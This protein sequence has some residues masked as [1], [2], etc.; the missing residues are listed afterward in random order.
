MSRRID[1]PECG[2][3]L[4]RLV[5]GGPEVPARIYRQT[6]TCE[7]G[8]A[9][10]AMDRPGFL[11]AEISGEPVE[12]ESVWH[13]RGREIDSYE[14]AVALESQIHDRIFRPQ[15]PSANP[16]KRIDLLTTAL[17]F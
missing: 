14:Y 10:N 17:P 4:L 7:P 12:I 2:F 11:V 1:R 5:K 13:R 9:E 15:S 16:T 6:T 8:N 3:W